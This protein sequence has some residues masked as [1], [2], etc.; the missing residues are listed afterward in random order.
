MSLPLANRLNGLTLSF[1]HEI[2]K[3]SS[4]Q[5]EE[6][7]YMGDFVFNG[8]VGSCFGCSWPILG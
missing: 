2:L 5:H 7:P 8:Q 4:T 3:K 1:S 6:H